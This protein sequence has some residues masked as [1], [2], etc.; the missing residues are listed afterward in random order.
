MDVTLRQ[1]SAS[2]RGTFMAWFR[3]PSLTRWHGNPSPPEAEAEFKR[4]LH[5]RY[6]FVIVANGHDAGHV[7][8]ESEWDRTRPQNSALSSTHATGDAASRRKHSPA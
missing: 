7:A 5:S 3:D 4:I 2:D 8:L 6:N 1:V